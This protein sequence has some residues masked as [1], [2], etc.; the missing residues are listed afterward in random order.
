MLKNSSMPGGPATAAVC[1][2]RLSA[3]CGSGGR[4][5]PRGLWSGWLSVA[6]ILAALGLACG[7]GAAGIAYG[8]LNNFDT[9]ND[10][11][12]PCHGFEIELE[13][14]ESVDVT[15]TYDW[16]HYGTPTIVE[17][18]TSLPGHTR[19]IVRYA[20]AKQ[21]DG[22][23]A[24][25]TAVPAGPIAPTDGH[26]FTDPSVNFGGEH[27][28]VGYRRVPTTVR[29]FWLIDDGSGNLVRGGAVSVATPTFTYVPAAA[30]VPAQVQAAIEPPEPPEVP[31]LEFGPAMWVKEI[32]TTRHNNREVKLRDLVSDD[33]DDSDD[34][35]WRNGEPDEVEVEWQLLQTEFSKPDGGENGE[36]EG[37]PE[38]LPNGDEVVTRRYEF[39]K[40]IGPVD[41]E[42]GEAKA[43]KV[44]PD[45]IHGRGIKTINGVEVDLATV[46]VVGEYIGAQMSAVDVDAP[47]GLIEHLQ[48]G[49]RDTPY[50]ARTVVVGGSR[51]FTATGEGSLPAGLTF[52]PV[53]GVLSGTPT[54]AG[55]FSFTVKASDEATPQVTRT[56]SFRIADAGAVLPPH[57][58]IDTT[59]SPAEG[60]TATGSGSY[61]PGL[62]ITVVATP[63]RGFSFVQWTENG[64]VVSRAAR[65]SFITP[66][67]RSLVAHF[68]ARPALTLTRTAADTLRL[69]W[70]DEEGEWTLQES[71]DLVAGPWA[72]STRPVS[73]VGGERQVTLSPVTGRSFFRL[74][75]P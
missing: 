72:N 55:T 9:V 27:F 29:Y 20:S 42:S 57:Q 62:E 68:A 51:P 66:V 38:N 74:L 17:D 60:G 6:G 56:Y 21:A 19:V 30:G 2:P 1:S 26:R 61:E 5:A 3:A 71:P 46:E 16:N 44:G 15:H 24:A 50:P 43:S 54:E 67:N 34:R 65:Y 58:V 10:T 70:S 53:T 69:S 36:L 52:D 35:N 23:W 37:A 48:D 49:E 31:V 8:S 73:V 41:E 22:T 64:E 11:G 75:H 14:L 33:P 7:A 59:A 12:V 39:Y 47:V 40:Y 25:Y 45:G 13:D 4:R 32:R 18:R 63:N 28:G